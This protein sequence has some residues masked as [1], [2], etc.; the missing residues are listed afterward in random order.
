MTQLL[1]CQ[2]IQKTYQDGKLETQVLRDVS[3]SL[4]S[5]DFAAIV[6]SSGSG[7]STLLHILGALDTAQSGKVQLLGQDLLALS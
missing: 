7:K 4:N 5:G 6:G 2:N 1:S 3:L